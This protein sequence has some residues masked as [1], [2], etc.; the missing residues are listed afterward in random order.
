MPYFCE[1]AIRYICQVRLVKFFQ[2]FH[3]DKILSTYGQN[4]VDGHSLLSSNIT[5]LHFS[6]R[7]FIYKRKIIYKNGLTC[8]LVT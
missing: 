1:I 4:K 2:L 5:F 7:Y 6:N 3:L 8:H